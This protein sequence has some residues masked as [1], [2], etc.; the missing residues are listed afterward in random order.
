MDSPHSPSRAQAMYMSPSHLAANQ[1]RAASADT[2]IEL[3]AGL[4]QAGLALFPEG[5]HGLI[6]HFRECLQLHFSI[7]GVI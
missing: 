4:L 5:H 7:P 1:T 2:C 3:H 6:A